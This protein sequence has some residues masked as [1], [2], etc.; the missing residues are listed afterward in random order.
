VPAAWGYGR[1]CDRPDGLLGHGGRAGA[2]RRAE[3]QRV[4]CAGATD[5]FSPAAQ[6]LAEITALVEFKTVWHPI[7]A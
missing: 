4:H 3:R 5:P 6:H 7:G 2:R 1:Q